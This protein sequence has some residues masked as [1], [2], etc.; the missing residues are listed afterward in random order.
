MRL[1][2]SAEQKLG[3][4]ECGNAVFAVIALRQEKGRDGLRLSQN[5]GVPIGAPLS[6][7]SRCFRIC[8]R[9]LTEVVH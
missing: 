7:G 3:D 5:R 6:P 8:R 1:D 9:L 2:L 4:V